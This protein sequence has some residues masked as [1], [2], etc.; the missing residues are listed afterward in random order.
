MFTET[1]YLIIISTTLFLRYLVYT[2]EM[3]LSR[4]LK[5]SHKIGSVLGV[6][7]SDLVG[8]FAFRITLNLF[9]R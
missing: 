9:C 1:K 6:F 4:H 3:S 7:L 2:V 8:Y 5:Q